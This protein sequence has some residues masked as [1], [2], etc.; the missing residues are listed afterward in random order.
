[1][2]F[3]REL[4]IELEIWIELEIGIEIEI[5]NDVEFE[6]EFEFKIENE[7]S[8]YCAPESTLLRHT[9]ALLPH[10][11]RTRTEIRITITTKQSKFM[12]H[13]HATSERNNKHML[14]ANIMLR[15]SITSG[16]PPPSERALPNNQYENRNQ[17]KPNTKT[18]TALATPTRELAPLKSCQPYISRWTAGNLNNSM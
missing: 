18:M 6:T 3:E 16:S 9:S 5:A 14:P 1:M 10:R 2:E 13:R 11:T 4:E 12:R 7:I 8:P 15:V 17:T